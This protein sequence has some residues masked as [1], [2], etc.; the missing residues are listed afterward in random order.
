MQAPAR[1]HSK[2]GLFG[3]CLLCLQ[4]GRVGSWKQAA[5]GESHVEAVNATLFLL[6]H[7]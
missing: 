1:S 7:F 6:F 5:G 2:S 3:L 4:G